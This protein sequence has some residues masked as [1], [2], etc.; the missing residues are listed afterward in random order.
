MLGYLEHYPKTKIH[1]ISHADFFGDEKYNLNLCAER[2]QTVYDYLT[3]N[4]L[5]K[6]RVRLSSEEE[7]TN[8]IRQDIKDGNQKARLVEFLVESIK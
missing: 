5:D 7:Q 2:A 8:V 4:G 6:S 1:I 3:S